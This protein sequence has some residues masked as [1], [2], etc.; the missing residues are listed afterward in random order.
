MSQD[1]VAIYHQGQLP[2][3]KVVRL[4]NPGTWCYANA[5]INFLFSCPGFVT[6]INNCYKN[7]NRSPLIKQLYALLMMKNEDIGSVKAIVFHCPSTANEMVG[8]N[9]L[10][11]KFQSQE[12]VPMKKG[13]PISSFRISCY[14]NSGY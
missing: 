9:L 8:S 7:P 3:Q 4:T 2:D 5:S 10:I 13:G 1:R 14:L 6:Y 12:K 11:L